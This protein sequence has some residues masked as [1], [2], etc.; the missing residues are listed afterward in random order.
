MSN[1][2]LKIVGDQGG[3]SSLESAMGRAIGERYMVVAKALTDSQV[4]RP[5][6]LRR[7]LNTP[8]HGA[9]SDTAK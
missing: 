1:K 4:C 6:M 9:T 3:Y 8:R 2:T 7:H 5:M